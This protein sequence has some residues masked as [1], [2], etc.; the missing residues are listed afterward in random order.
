M[1]QRVGCVSLTDTFSEIA[2]YSS[3]EEYLQTDGI[4][5][6]MSFTDILVQMVERV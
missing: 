6:K 2:Q 4:L 5:D 1:P 3:I